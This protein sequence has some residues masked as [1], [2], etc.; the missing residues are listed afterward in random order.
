GPY[1]YCQQ[2][3]WFTDSFGTPNIRS[4]VVFDGVA[5]QFGWNIID[6]RNLVGSRAVIEQVSLICIKKL[7]V[8]K[9]TH[10][11]HEASYNLSAIDT[12]ID[13]TPGVHQNIYSVYFHKAGKSID[14]DFRY[15]CTHGEI[16]KW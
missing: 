5:V 14:L 15:G 16:E 11:L 10:P 6:V 1:G 7:L 3:R 2:K 4:I 8:G 13:G 12:G 9:P